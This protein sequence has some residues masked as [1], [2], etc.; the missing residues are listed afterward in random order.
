MEK[1]EIRELPSYLKELEDGAILGSCRATEPL[2]DV[3][4]YKC[5]PDNNVWLAE[6]SDKLV[7]GDQDNAE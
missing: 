7:L 1:A 3:D 6:N 2:R 5:T 4:S